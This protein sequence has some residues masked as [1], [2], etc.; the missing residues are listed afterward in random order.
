MLLCGWRLDALEFPSH[1][2]LTAYQRHARYLMYHDFGTEQRVSGEQMTQM[3]ANTRCGRGCGWRNDI[4][5]TDIAGVPSEW[6]VEEEMVTGFRGF[7]R[8]SVY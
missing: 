7:K 8:I 2:K 3:G 6:F 1:S 4:V 5:D